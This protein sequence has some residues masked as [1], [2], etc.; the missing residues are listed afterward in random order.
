MAAAICVAFAIVGGLQID[1]IGLQTDE[2]LF[3]GGI[4]AP[5]FATAHV[6]G[7]EIPL[8]V[9]QYVGA[10]KGWLYGALFAVWAPSAA[11]I[12]W[13]MVLLA[14]WTLWLFYC[15]AARVTGGRGALLALTV[16]ATDPIFLLTS[17][18][19]WGPVVIQHFCLT[20][21]V[22]AF[23]RFGEARRNWWLA[24]G[25][26]LLGVGVWDKAIFVWVLVGLAAGAA[27]GLA[28]PLKRL[29][30]IRQWAMAG[31]AFLLG[32][33]PLVFYNIQNAGITYRGNAG[34]SLT[35]LSAKVHALWSVVDGTALYGVIA[36]PEGERWVS[37]Q[38]VLAAATAAAL[39]WAWKRHGR[40]IRFTCAY[41]AA[42]WGMMAV[43]EGAGVSAHHVIL[44]W[45][46]PHLALAAAAE[47]VPWRKAAAVVTGV[48]A[49]ANA[50]VCWQYYRQEE[51]GGGTVVWTEAIYSLPETL[52]AMNAERLYVADW[53]FYD[54]SRLL[55]KGT[56]E[57][58]V[59]HTGVPEE[60]LHRM[61]TEPEHA[62]VFVRHTPGNAVQPETAAYLE[63]YMAAN[64]LARTDVRVLRDRKGRAV[65][66][67]FR[68]RRVTG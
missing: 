64:G 52:R 19:D 47:A 21:G 27:A 24:L 44:L 15:V 51:L 48:G 36:R 14:A 41:C 22:Y 7:H 65:I 18:Y 29:M 50:A 25:S 12:R 26:L 30:T 9:M 6:G 56:L 62:G 45:P 2:A 38:W 10:A 37:W 42:G 33:W 57:L 16:L 53:G 34:Y 66:E 43:T 23:V 39:P 63:K 3:A 5:F 58:R 28:G 31:A 40:V 49:L 60:V 35:G 59:V 1:R 68:V 46:I 54:N 32:A 13:P 4:Y 61:M 55:T 20:A 17:R 67:L 11:V 8:M